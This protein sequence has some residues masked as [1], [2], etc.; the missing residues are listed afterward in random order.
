MVQLLNFSEY[1][2][3]LEIHFIGS[4]LRHTL[5]FHV[6]YD[7]FKMKKKNLLWHQQERFRKISGFTN[8]KYFAVPQE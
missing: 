7:D 1:L 4:N 6:I 5:L 2:E 8:S 3:V